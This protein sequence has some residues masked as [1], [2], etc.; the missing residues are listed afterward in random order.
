[1]YYMKCMMG[2]I[3]ILLLLIHICAFAFF[4]QPHQ[5]LLPERKFRFQTT[6]MASTNEIAKRLK[7]ANV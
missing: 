3:K 7:H 1:M 2:K 4:I 5:H 6:P